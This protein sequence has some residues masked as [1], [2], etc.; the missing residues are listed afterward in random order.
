[1]LHIDG[2]HNSTDN[3]TVLP[4]TCR[5]GH[6]AVQKPCEHCRRAAWM[7]YYQRN[8]RQLIRNHVAWKQNQQLYG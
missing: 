8:R 7:R 3:G 4:R 1:M 2:G 5:N 6:E